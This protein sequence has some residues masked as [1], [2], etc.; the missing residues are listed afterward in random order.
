[1]RGL[2][3]VPARTNGRDRLYVITTDGRSTAWYDR[4]TGRISLLSEEDAGAV[5]AALGP[6]L[7]GS[8]TLGPPP[9]P[10]AAEVARLSLPP[11]DDLAPNRPGE[12]LLGAS[13][14]GGAHRSRRRGKTQSLRLALLA[15]QRIGAELDALEGAGWRV[16]HCV[17][18]PG[19][20]HIDHLLIGPGGV[21]TVRSVH[22]RRQRAAVGDLLLSVG[23]AE[24][25]PEPRWARREAL[26]ASHALAAAVVPVLAL[27]EA[28]RV[29]VARTLRDVRVV[30]AGETGAA[31]GALG[32][33]LKPDDVDALHA[34]ARDRR[35]WLRV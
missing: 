21:L 9:V 18:L 31:F 24:P 10:T 35:T 6:F 1:M 20:V 14:Y 19:A 4:D 11:D 29:E 27:C 23:R 28:S 26:R 5:L 3:V 8:Y 12:A 25:R 34:R 13:Q 16:L 2:R 17:P 7:S 32:A 33:V 15:Q 22:A 30:R